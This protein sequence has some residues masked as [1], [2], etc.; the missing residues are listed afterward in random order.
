MSTDIEGF[1]ELRDSL[2]DFERKARNLRGTH[3]V[4]FDKLFPKSF[5]EK[6]TGFPSFD[7]FLKAGNFVVNSTEDFEAIPKD[8]WN[9]YVSHASDFT[10]WDDMLNQAINAYFSPVLSL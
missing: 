2:K 6:H 4:S 10:S 3:A 8:V 1:D 5:M 9:Q 7:E